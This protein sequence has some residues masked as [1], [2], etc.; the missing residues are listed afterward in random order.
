MND[1]TP[2]SPPV[3]GLP[4]SPRSDAYHNIMYM[5]QEL[6][7]ARFALARCMDRLDLVQLL[8]VFTEISETLDG[9]ARPIPPRLI[10]PRE[11]DR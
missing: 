3:Q 8:D 10:T 1:H 6:L 11:H 5:A 4:R 7:I 2:G 9:P